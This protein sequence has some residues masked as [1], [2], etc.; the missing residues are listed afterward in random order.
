MENGCGYQKMNEHCCKLCGHC[1]DEV[2]SMMSE[3]EC[4]CHE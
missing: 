3:C 2:I 4:G 1:T